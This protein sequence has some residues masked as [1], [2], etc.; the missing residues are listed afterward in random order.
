MILFTTIFVL[1]TL[2]FIILFLLIKHFHHTKHQDKAS[3]A[4]INDLSYKAYYDSLTGLYNRSQLQSSVEKYIASA[5]RNQESFTVFFIDLDYFKQINDRLGHD[6]GD[7]VIRVVAERLKTNIRQ[8]DIAARLGG[9]EFILVLN[10][11]RTSEIAAAFAEK[12]LN[13]L[14][15]PIKIKDHELLISA[16]IGICFYPDNGKNFESLV[17]SADLA[18]YKAKESGRHNYQF[19][20]VEMNDE[21]KEK[22]KF[23]QDLQIALNNHE[24][25]L[26]YL[27]KINIKTNAITGFEAL[28]RWKDE[29]YG[30]VSPNKIIPLADEMGVISQLSQWIMETAMEQAKRWQQYGVAQPTRIAINVSPKHYIE[31]NFLNNILEVLQK[32]QFPSDYLQLEINENLI[33][34]DPEYSLKIIRELK[35]NG[36]QIIIDNFGTGYSS[37]N[38]LHQFGVDYIKIDRRFTKNTDS[39]D[40]QILFIEAMTD[41]AKNLNIKILAEG[42]E[43]QE[44]MELLT[45]IGCDEIQGYYISPPIPADQIPRFLEERAKLV[46]PIAIK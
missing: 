26:V 2:L 18:L 3:Q 1:S 35:Q 38:Y 6:F 21:I 27:P 34:R 29:K 16:S 25:H 42:I 11:I 41:L 31:E 36:I 14:I 22:L 7:E 37:L 17:K 33:M 28:L 12:I 30:D 40:Q 45:R 13:V 46:S 4:T 8:T 32:I 24:F 19:C 20:T 15:K 44:Q 5:L 43:T 39:N 10:G 23:K 9:D